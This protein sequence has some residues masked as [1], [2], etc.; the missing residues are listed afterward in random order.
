MT[1]L[2]G[3]EA[4]PLGSVVHFIE[5]P[6][7]ACLAAFSKSF[8]EFRDG[9]QAKETGLRFDHALPFLLP[10]EAPWSRLLVARCGQWTAIT[11]NGLY[12]GDST[13]PGPA[14]SNL[15][16]VRCAVASCVPRYGPGHEQTQLEIFGP[17]GDPPLMYVRSISATATDGR[18]E[19]YT[20]GSPLAFEDTERYAVRLVKKRFD[21]DLLLAY[22][23]ALGI[24]ADR[25][26]SYGAAVLLQNNGSYQRREMTLEQSRANFF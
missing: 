14:I 16:G 15:L 4:N 9:G 10:L 1:I 12:G 2:L 23:S 11:N 26:E 18:W 21:R 17:A 8:A 24:P 22:L 6:V 3:G 5:A 20:S 19:W 25:D 7:E 13:A